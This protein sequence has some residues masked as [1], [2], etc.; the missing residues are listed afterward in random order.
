ML[1][2][3]STQ[4]KSPEFQRGWYQ[5][6][7][8]REEWK[9]LLRCYS[10]RFMSFD[11]HKYSLCPP[12]RVLPVPLGQ[13]LGKDCRQ[14]GFQ[15][16]EDGKRILAF[17]QPHRAKLFGLNVEQYLHPAR[18]IFVSVLDRLDNRIMDVDVV[19][20]EKEL[21]TEEMDID[22]TVESS[23]LS[24][25]DKLQR[26]CGNYPTEKWLTSISKRIE[27]AARYNS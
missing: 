20:D 17:S 10:P 27:V 11:E 18:G 7:T 22:N 19:D 21:A 15:L 5:D 25:R 16:T 6:D 3:S 4:K 2:L 13:K 24:E 26:F 1:P 9:E 14:S 8:P 23:D 12:L